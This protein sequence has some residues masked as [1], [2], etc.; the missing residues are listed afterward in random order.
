MSA[1]KARVY[2]PSRRADKS[3]I[4]PVVN[5]FNR[6]GYTAVFNPDDRYDALLLYGAPI[7][8]TPL[9]YGELPI[10]KYARFD[11][12]ADRQDNYLFRRLPPSMPK[13]GIGRGGH[14]LNALSGGRTLQH[15]TN[16]IGRGTH[17]L[18]LYDEAAEGDTISVPSNHV[19]LMVSGPGGLE[20]GWAKEAFLKKSD[21]YTRRYDQQTRQKVYDDAE[22]IHYE[23]TG[24]LCVQ[25]DPTEGDAGCQNAFFDYVWKTIN[26]KL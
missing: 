12:V 5:L 6:Y 18:K 16:H 1:E 4:L 8:V 19:E 20:I 11:I 9:L 17:E 3:D 14:L 15:V 13:I 10:G 25:F 26:E 24:S 2:V 22:I 23:Q 7:G 21:N